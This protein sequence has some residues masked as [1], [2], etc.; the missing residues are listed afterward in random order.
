MGT[1][2]KIP[3]VDRQY[4]TGFEKRGIITLCALLQQG[5]SNRAGCHYIYITMV[6]NKHFL[7]QQQAT[8]P[9]KTNTACFSLKLATVKSAG[10]DSL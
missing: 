8:I 9:A 3:G 5:L 10:G 7:F 4:V 2:K 6:L 1:K